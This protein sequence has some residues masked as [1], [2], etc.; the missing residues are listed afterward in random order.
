MAV[1]LRSR[2]QN[3]AR[4]GAK[5]NPRFKTSWGLQPA[6]RPTDHWLRFE[7]LNL[8]VTNN[9]AARSAGYQII[10]AQILGLAPQ[11]LCFR[12]LRRLA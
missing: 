12:L 2:R 10:R 11:A 8:D 5:R 9:A 7:F 4:G 6:E 3:K 1:S